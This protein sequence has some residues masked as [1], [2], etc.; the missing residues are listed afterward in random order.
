MTALGPGEKHQIKVSHSQHNVRKP[1]YANKHTNTPLEFMV[2]PK[3]RKGIDCDLRDGQGVAEYA[4]ALNYINSCHNMINQMMMCRRDGDADV[5]QTVLMPDLPNFMDVYKSLF[6]SDKNDSKTKLSRVGSTAN[7]NRTEYE[8]ESSDNERN[9]D[10]QQGESGVESDNDVFD[11]IIIHDDADYKNE[12]FSPNDDG[13]ETKIRDDPQEYTHVIPNEDLQVGAHL[14]HSK[15]RS[16]V[17][18]KPSRS[19]NRDVI[20]EESTAAESNQRWRTHK[21]LDNALE[22]SLRFNGPEVTN[23]TKINTPRSISATKN[24]QSFS[25]SSYSSIHIHRAPAGNDV[26]SPGRTMRQRSLSSSAHSMPRTS[27]FD[28]K[29]TKDVAAGAVATTSSENAQD[30]RNRPRKPFVKEVVN[31]SEEKLSQSQLDEFAKEFAASE[32]VTPR[33]GS[34]FKSRFS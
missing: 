15:A 13:Y 2:C 26:G 10:N 27:N 1:A 14:V 31:R 11:E 16:G 8:Y 18:N 12:H 21:D 3:C 24:A 32:N 19:N 25:N 9:D 22:K 7:E 33:S 20:V 30:R 4:K 5:S 29:N 17:F 34:Y 28:A 23:S 6:K